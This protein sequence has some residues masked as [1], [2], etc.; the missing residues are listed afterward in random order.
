MGK[1]ILII[2]VL[3]FTLFSCNGSNDNFLCYKS[4]QK[5]YPNSK[6]IPIINRK[7]KFFVKN[8]KGVIYYIETMDKFST[9]ITLEYK[10]EF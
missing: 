2:L 3:S 5:K 9:D 4:V 7:Y 8:D 10:I 6:I 1:K